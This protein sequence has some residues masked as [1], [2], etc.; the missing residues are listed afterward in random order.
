MMTVSGVFP[1]ENPRPRDENIGV[2]RRKGA[3]FPS[4][5]QTF[6]K[7]FSPPA[8]LSLASVLGLRVLAEGES[9]LASGTQGNSCE[10]G[11]RTRCFCCHTHSSSLCNP[12]ALVSHQKQS[13]A[14]RCTPAIP[15][16]RMHDQEDSHRL[17][18]SLAHTVSSRPARAI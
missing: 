9:I 4:S 16:F 15:A 11:E 3:E 8:S 17:E 5:Q 18:D 13:Q 2:L 6:K 1:N 7:F 10:A 14:K 12:R